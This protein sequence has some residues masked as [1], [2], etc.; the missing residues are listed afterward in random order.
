MCD[1]IFCYGSHNKKRLSKYIKQTKHG[2]RLYLD[3]DNFIK[4]KIKTHNN[5]KYIVVNFNDS[6]DFLKF[7]IR[8]KI[9][10]QKTNSHNCNS[11]FYRNNYLE[12]IVKNKYLDAIKIFFKE[13]IPMITIVTKRDFFWDQLPLIFFDLDMVKHILK[14][15]NL[16]DTKYIFYDGLR[17]N[18]D[19]ITIEF[20]DDII[21][22]YKKKITRLFAENIITSHNIYDNKIDE[23]EFIIPALEKDD[24]DLFYFVVEEICNLTN[25]IDKTKLDNKQLGLLKS[26]EFNFDVKEINSFIGNLLLPDFNTAAIDTYCC[27]NIFR[28]IIFSLDN[29]DS[30]MS[31]FFTNILDYDIIEYMRVICDFIGDTNPKFINKMLTEAESTEMAQLL[32]DNGADYEKLYESTEFS[33]CDDC[34]KK[35]IKNL[36]NE[37]ADP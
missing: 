17:E 23:Y 27:P 7:I 10:C 3:D 22:I 20:M 8:K 18:S 24:V 11:I 32:I 4:V 35:F 28:Q 19:F 16:K 25:K 33:K 14:N 30:L 21:S 2:Y 37:T 12:H 29:I 6:I 1:F 36:I 15:G 34:I 31:D 9:Y 26:F 13:F 5:R